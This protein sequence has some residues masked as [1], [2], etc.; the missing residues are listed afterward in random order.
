MRWWRGARSP[1]ACP[2]D[3]TSRSTSTP[4]ST[5]ISMVSRINSRRLVTMLAWLVAAPLT[6]GAQAPSPAPLRLSFA[7]AVRLASGEVPVVALATLRASEADARVRQARSALLPSLSVG[8]SW[9]NRTFNSKSLRIDF[10]P[11]PTG[12]GG[13]LQPAVPGLAGPFATYD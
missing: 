11:V 1:R 7:D 9:L 6:L 5:C 2:R 10:P 8:G 13:P 3:S 12:P 4:T